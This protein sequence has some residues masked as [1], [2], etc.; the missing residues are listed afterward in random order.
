MCG[1]VGAV[2]DPGRGP[3]RELGTRAARAALATRGPDGWDQLEEPGL[4]F[5]HARLAII[6]VSDAGAQPMASACGRY[7]IV[8]NGEIYN[9][10]EVRERLGGGIP[11]R[12]QSDTETILQAF[13]RWGVGCVS[14][15]HGMFAFAI[16]DRAERRLTLVRDRLGVK[17]LYY[18]H[19]GS[20]FAFASRPR[21]LVGLVPGVGREPDR[22]AVRFYLE[23]GYVPAPLSFHAGVKK[24]GPGQFLEFDGRE[25]RV[26]TWWSLDPVPVQP[27]LARA[28]E[29]DLLDELEALVERSVRWRLV[30]DVPVGAFLSG[31]IDSSLVA[32][33]MARNT[34]APIR[35]FTIGFD[36]PAFDESAHAAA[37]ARHLGAQHVCERLTADDL[38]SLMPVF[39]EHY[40]EPFFDY[41]AFP[42]MAVSRLAS[43]SVKVSLS[44]DG[45]DEAFGGYH[46]YR[47]ARALGPALRLPGVLRRTIACGAARLPGRGRL[48]GHALSRQSSPSAFAFSRGVIKD[49][50]DIFAPSLLD[51]T[52]SLS[53]LFEQRAAG[54]AAGIGAAEQAMRL[55]V[56]YTLP[57]D[58][59]QKVDVGSMAF[60]LEAR[61][62]LL[63]HTIFEWAA[64]LPLRWKIRGRTNKYLLRQLAYRLVP[65][66]LL[67]RPK[68]GFG[69]P[70]GRWLREGL[71]G[72]GEDLL[73]DPHAMTRLE[74]DPEA[75]RRLWRTH[76]SGVRD[77]HTALW[78]VLVLLQFDRAAE[79]RGR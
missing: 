10:R 7:V 78:A 68:R 52:S 14:R 31:G 26:E 64:R 66:E 38:L 47:I 13:A 51:G 63:E 54:F 45:G 56:A 79:G 3:R 44:G 19:D 4:Y 74:L 18:A 21:A 9:F 62:P 42:V 46:Y 36:D 77:A 5:G 33:M 71:R 61:D 53:D 67:D 8:F 1:I 25:T 27:A 41:S 15:F 30:S 39:V 12:S 58:Y 28:S 72:W 43:R 55:D 32:A 75:V 70:M 60:S 16:W 34:A 22:Q 40:D 50:T 65:R 23:A 48:L 57:D 6:D 69:V 2:F 76:Q 17:P 35:T 49:A 59:L 20:L 73:A 37:V 24:L 11:W 29:E